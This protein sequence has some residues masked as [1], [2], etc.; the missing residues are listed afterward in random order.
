MIYTATKQDLGK[1][2][3]FYA[4]HPFP[5]ILMV[6]LNVAIPDYYNLSL[7]FIYPGKCKTSL[8]S[9]LHPQLNLIVYRARLFYHFCIL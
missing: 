5:I 6:T 9:A 2:I 4:K 8:V 7:F 3:C 1:C